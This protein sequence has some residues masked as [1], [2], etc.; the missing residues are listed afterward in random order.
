MST[1]APKI[2]TLELRQ[3]MAG[4][5][6]DCTINDLPMLESTIGTTALSVASPDALPFHW[7]P[8]PSLIQRA[9]SNLVLVSEV[10]PGQ[11]ILWG[12]RE[13]GAAGAEISFHIDL[14]D[15]RVQQLLVDGN[16][17]L[18][19]GETGLLYPMAVEDRMVPPTSDLPTG[20]APYQDK[21]VLAVNLTNGEVVKELTLAPG[22][23]KHAQFVDG[24]ALL[25]VDSF[26]LNVPSLTSPVSTVQ[27]LDANDEVYRFSWGD[28]GVS[29][30]TKDT[31]PSGQL[32]VAGDRLVVATFQGS[33]DPS[34]PPGPPKAVLSSFTLTANDIVPNGRLELGEGYVSNLALD[35]SGDRATLIRQKGFRIEPSSNQLQLLDLTTEA[36]TIDETIE[37]GGQ[38]Q[39]LSQAD[40]YLLLQDYGA[41]KIS[42]V[43]LDGD[44]TGAARVTEIDLPEGMI[45]VPNVIQLDGDRL[46][47]FGGSGRRPLP[48]DARPVHIPT[49]S[50]LI[51]LSLAD[52]TIKKQELSDVSSAT[53]LRLIDSATG[54]FGF[55]TYSN[56]EG[57]TLTHAFAFGTL[58]H[59]GR[60][61][62]DGKVE[63]TTWLESFS[64]DANRLTVLSP[65]R[66]TAY[67]Y[68]DTTKP[69]YSLRLVD[70]AAPPLKAID[71]VAEFYLTKNS[72]SPRPVNWD[73]VIHVLANDQV[74]FGSRAETHITELIDAPDGVNIVDGQYLSLSPNKFSAAGKLVFRYRMSDGFS[75]SE[76][77]VEITMKAISDELRAQMVSAVKAK[78]A[79]DLNLPEDQINVE[80]DIDFPANRFPGPLPAIAAGS[81]SVSGTNEQQTELSR[82]PRFF[83]RV[84]TPRINAIYS[85]DIAGNAF[86]VWSEVTKLEPLVALTLA[87]TDEASKPIEKVEVGQIFWLEFRGDDLRSLGEGVFSAYLNLKL[88]STVNGSSESPGAAFDGTV[89]AGPG[90]TFIEGDKVSDK[91]KAGSISGLGVVSSS[92]TP[93][94]GAPQLLIR[95][96]AKADRAG[97][98]ALNSFDSQ[99]VNEETLIFGLG[100]AL[101][102]TQIRREAVRLNIVEAVDGSDPADV[103]GD[104]NVRAV[105]ALRIVNFI[106][107]HGTGTFEQINSRMHGNAIN[108][109]ANGEMPSSNS[110]EMTRLDVNRSGSITALDALTVINR[111]SRLQRR[112]AASGSNENVSG[113]TQRSVAAVSPITSDPAIDELEQK[114]R[115]K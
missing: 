21:K 114:R 79:Q 12:V 85:V 112:A 71:D 32:A 53:G 106:G 54:H 99:N 3:L 45:I 31:I 9:G 17:L 59:E 14:G 13:G 47:M 104:G 23:V 1:H 69:L 73:N 107:R 19:I 61:V 97:T 68:D 44:V 60:F 105:D 41:G 10:S 115:R 51:T 35:S 36:P 80:F 8:T 78:A 43:N 70:P 28:S 55:E 111:V 90:M 5:G 66:V 16:R 92:T 58:N 29:E 83:A 25:V 110:D 46:L 22:F 100:E 42:L 93:P 18:V 96:R 39:M 63:V 76:A 81:T 98:I 27:D 102:A 74:P 103:D 48:L 34:Q 40:G 87:I 57:G 50:T 65:N 91:I 30:V 64:A 75:E 95:V 88:T 33:F 26:N 113:E 52:G 67:D 38:F 84:T 20:F 89:E 77:G 6:V 62:A 72:D 108:G 11:Q 15:L 4:D 56:A 7:Y 101:K 24:K 109:T 2:E 86:K 49:R 94:G 82:S 37:L